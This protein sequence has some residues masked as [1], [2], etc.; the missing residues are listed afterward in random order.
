MPNAKF[1]KSTA[2]QGED[3]FKADLNIV[4][5]IFPGSSARVQKVNFV[6]LNSIWQINQFCLFSIEWN[7]IRLGGPAHITVTKTVH[8]TLPRVKKG[9]V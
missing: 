2:N 1:P 9:G 8:K 3:N 7:S 5:T 6:S 4:M